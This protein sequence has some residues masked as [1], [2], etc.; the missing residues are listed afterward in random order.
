MR[1]IPL[2]GIY[3]NKS[4]YNKIFVEENKNFAG[5]DLFRTDYVAVPR[6]YGDT[7]RMVR[8][9]RKSTVSAGCAGTESGRGGCTDTGDVAFRS[10]LLFGDLS[11][12]RDAGY[13]VVVER[14]A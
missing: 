12:G 6:F 5:S 14:S 4:R 7:A 2:R 10:G 8:M 11:A 9:A 1:E 13:R 3:L